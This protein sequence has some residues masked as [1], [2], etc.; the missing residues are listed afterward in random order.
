MNVKDCGFISLRK[1]NLIPRIVEKFY[2]KTCD[3]VFF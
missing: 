2:Q 3:L 1:I